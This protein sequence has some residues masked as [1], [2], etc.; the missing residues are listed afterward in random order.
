MK[1]NVGDIVRIKENLIENNDY[2]VLTLW[3]SM[4]PY[5]G[6]VVTIIECVDE[7][8]E[9]YDVKENIYSWTMEML[10]PFDY[11]LEKTL[12]LLSVLIGDTKVN[13]Y[14]LKEDIDIPDWFDLNKI[15]ALFN[16]IDV[17]IKDDNDKY[18]SMYDILCELSKIREWL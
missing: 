3:D 6:D 5:V 12:N 1:Y 9:M 10:E 11:D 17:K 16:E 7:A 8:D 4:M 14:T 13:K 18:R 15:E 2:G